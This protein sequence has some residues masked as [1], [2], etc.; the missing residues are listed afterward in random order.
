MGVI[1]SDA[2]MSFKYSFLLTYFERFP[3]EEHKG[4]VEYSRFFEKPHDNLFWNHSS[5]P[6]CSVTSIKS[7]V[8]TQLLFF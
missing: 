6:L 2:N 7:F 1:H 8:N 4:K 3:A 5:K